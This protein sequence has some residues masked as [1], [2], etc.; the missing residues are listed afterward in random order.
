MSDQKLED[1]IRFIEGIGWF[2]SDDSGVQ[3]S[4][5]QTHMNVHG[6][7][8]HHCG[9]PTE[10]STKRDA[11]YRDLRAIIKYVKGHF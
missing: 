11:V 9:A 3:C 2:V 5:D 1:F 8:C 4:A 7:F 6:N 10:Q